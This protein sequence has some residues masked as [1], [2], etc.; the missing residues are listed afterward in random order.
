M[1]N[2]DRLEEEFKTLIQE[3]SSESKAP[4]NFSKN[5]MKTINE[6]HIKAPSILPKWTIGLFPLPLIIVAMLGYYFYT[7]GWLA[8]IITGLSNLLSHF[9][10]TLTTGLSAII[11]VVIY[12]CIA[13]FVVALL[14]LKSQSM[15]PVIKSF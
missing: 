13:R 14:L 5:V 8:P 6:Q 3:I 10:L 4:V 1:E 11:L 9:N 12:L 2:G 7:K 15:K